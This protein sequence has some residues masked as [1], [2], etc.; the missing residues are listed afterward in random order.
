ME[1]IPLAG[2]DLANN[3]NPQARRRTHIEG[4]GDKSEPD[5]DAL[6]CG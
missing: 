2:V 1:G 6:H 3:V 5:D 4:G